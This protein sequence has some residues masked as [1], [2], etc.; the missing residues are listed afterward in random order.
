MPH[1]VQILLGLALAKIVPGRPD[2]FGFA[3]DVVIDVGDILDVGHVEPLRAKVA[4][5]DV[6]RQKCE[7]VAGMCRVIRSHA[8]DIDSDLVADYGQRLYRSRR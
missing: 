7:G 5:Q 8:A 2:F 1:V 4:N 3:Q 6:E